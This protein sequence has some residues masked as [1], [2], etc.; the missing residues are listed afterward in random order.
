MMT[1]SM[2][3]DAA[4][5]LIDAEDEVN[6]AVMILTGVLDGRTSEEAYREFPGLTAERN[7]LRRK[8]LSLRGLTLSE[9]EES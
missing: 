6:S 9:K 1:G 4:W 2:T 7:R 5:R 3:L 8:Y